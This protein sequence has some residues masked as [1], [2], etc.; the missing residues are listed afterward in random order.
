MA[1]KEESLKSSSNNKH[2][3][4]PNILKSS[5]NKYNMLFLNTTQVKSIDAESTYH[6]EYA[7]I[8]Q[9]VDMRKAL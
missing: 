8:Q 1:S 5:S 2:N 4:S 7:I 9:I 6:K 3:L